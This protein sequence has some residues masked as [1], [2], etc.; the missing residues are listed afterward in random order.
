MK[1]NIMKEWVSA[2]RSGE[3]K[4]GVNALRVNDKF[5]CLGVLCNLHAQSHPKIAKKQLDPE[6]YLGED[7]ILP[8]SVKDWAGMKSTDGCFYS[9]DG[10]TD[11]L[12]EL[13]DDGATFDEIA[14]IIEKH[15]KAL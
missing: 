13:N 15:Y 4:Q 12:V 6:Y 8:E 7:K 14:N 5:C 10:P 3:Y 1:K 2:L 9:D 11:T